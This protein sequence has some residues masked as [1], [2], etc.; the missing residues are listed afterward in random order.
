MFWWILLE[1]FIV[2]TIIFMGVYIDSYLNRLENEIF[3]FRKEI[4]YDLTKEIEDLERDVGD[5]RRIIEES[6]DCV[7]KLLKKN[8]ELNKR[9][10]KLEKNCVSNNDDL[11]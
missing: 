5:M 10:D 2:I 7:Y 9:I 1:I 3:K 8:Y 11:K 6:D 4:K